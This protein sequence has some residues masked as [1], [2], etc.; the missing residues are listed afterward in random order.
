MELLLQCRNVYFPDIP[1]FA[2]RISRKTSRI[3]SGHTDP[4]DAI[5][6]M[7][8]MGTGDASATGQKIA[9]TARC[10]T[11]VWN[12]IIL[13]EVRSAIRFCLTGAVGIVYVYTEIGVVYDRVGEL[14]SG[15]E[16]LTG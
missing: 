2:C 4:H 14:S 13:G 8:T 1:C 16:I 12:V 3:A 6:G 5:R 9:E 7:R 10:E 15:N 11:A